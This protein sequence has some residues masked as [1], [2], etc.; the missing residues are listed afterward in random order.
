MISAFVSRSFGVG[1]KLTEEELL[2]VNERRRSEKWGQYVET[3]AAIEVYGSTQKKE[4]K[5]PLT[6]VRFFD[7]GINE[8]GYWNYFHMALLI[9]DAFDVLSVKYPEYDFLILMDQSSGHG[10][11]MEGGLNAAEMSVKFGGSQQKM[12]NTT[13]NELGTYPAQ[14]KVG[15]TQSLT[16]T[17]GD[18]GPF[19]L[20]DE[21]R[22]GLRFDVFSGEKKTMKKTKK[23]LVDEIKQT[24]YQIRGHLSKD[25]LERIANSKQIEL[26]YELSVKKEGWMGKPKG[27]LQIFWN[28]GIIL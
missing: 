3:K 26:T 5:D 14:L 9:E 18:A 1:L 22:E 13:I 16:F 23:M 24:G 21:E 6:L 15:D 8:E 12:R 10:K 20:S 2:R 19:Y 17:Y 27:L 28:C 7:V 11:R 4:I 25:E